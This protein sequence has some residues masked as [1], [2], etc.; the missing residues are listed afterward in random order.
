MTITAKVIQHSVSQGIS[1][2]TFELEYPRFIHSELMTHR[3]FSRNAAS[4]RAIPISKMMEQI[5]LNP[6]KPVYWGLDMKGMKAKLAHLEPE[7]C[8]GVWE[9]AALAALSQARKLESLGLHKQIVNRVL[10]PFQTMK[11]IVTSTEWDNF[12][13]LRAHRDAQPEFKVLAEEMQSAAK[14]SVPFLLNAEEW[15]VPYVSRYRCP[16]YENIF[17]YIDNED[18]TELT[19]KQALMISSSCCAQ[20]SYRVLDDSLDKAQAIHDHLVSSVPMHASPFEHQAMPAKHNE[21]HANFKGWSQYRA[22]LEQM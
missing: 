18:Q 16:E 8:I 19:L 1:L 6:A 10:E 9:E 5:L 21:F 15:H 3:V 4:S 2:I 14:E 17:Y 7:K 20:V 11:T 22:K 13:N 12:Y